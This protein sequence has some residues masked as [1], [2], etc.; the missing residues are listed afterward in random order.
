MNN[1]KENTEKVAI[2][3]VGLPLSQW[4]ELI[5]KIDKMDEKLA[6]MTQEKADE[7][8][9]VEKAAEILRCSRLTI[10]NFIKRGK[11]KALKVGKLFYIKKGDVEALI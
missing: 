7:V 11:L 2:A 1:E 8:I 6:K 3:A 9:N 5:N 4:N 10:Y